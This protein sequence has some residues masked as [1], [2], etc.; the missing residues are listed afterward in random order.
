MTIAY[1]EGLVE[2]YSLLTVSDIFE[3]MGLHGAPFHNEFGI[4][5]KHGVAK[6]VYRVFEAL[7]GA[8]NRRLSVE[9]SHPTAG[10]AG[11]ERGKAGHALCLQSR[12]R[13][14]GHCAP[15][16]GTDLSSDRLLPSR[17]PLST[18][19]TAIRKKP[20]RRWAARRT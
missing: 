2:G 19:S 5:T 9:G 10:G 20:G 3:E 1:N 4:Q 15:G 7:H 18:W 16:D 8:G 13:A 6:P 14:Q 12:Y 17:R 11:S